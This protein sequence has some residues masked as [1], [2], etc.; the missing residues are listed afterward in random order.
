MKNYTSSIVLNKLKY[1]INCKRNI[2]KVIE[3]CENAIKQDNTDAMLQLADIYWNDIDIE[4]N[5]EKI[6]ELYT[7]AINRGNT[8]AM[9]RLAQIFSI[10]MYGCYDPVKSLELLEIAAINNNPCAMI[11]LAYL[12][13]CGDGVPQDLEKM[14][15]LQILAN[16]L[17]VEGIS[18]DPV[19][20]IGYAYSNQHGL[21]IPAN[22][23]MAIQLYKN[24]FEK[25]YIAGLLGLAD[26]YL[27]DNHFEEY[28]QSLDHAIKMGNFKAVMNLADFYLKGP[29][30][31]YNSKKALELYIIGI[32]KKHPLA[33]HKFANFCKENNETDFFLENYFK[34]YDYTKYDVNL[35]VD[36]FNQNITWHKFIHKWWPY[37]NKRE[38]NNIILTV[39][40]ISKFRHRNSGNKFLI[41]GIAIM[42]IEKICMMAQK[43]RNV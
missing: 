43:K 34:Y 1:G 12:Y 40:L 23:N 38:I 15:E 35:G 18:D 16:K 5:C 30:K 2:K 6:I 31:Y 10:R 27:K 13:K 4:F 41:Q 39:L 36:L 25:N 11:R 33:L 8:N 7:E 26:I 21:N 9:V 3:T 37:E 42:I 19:A 22:K 29:D 32:K 28:Q 17:Y 14:S 24:A 20:M